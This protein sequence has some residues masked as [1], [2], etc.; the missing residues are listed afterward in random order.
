MFFNA[1]L[2]NF[3]IFLLFINW[4]IIMK[5]QNKKYK[6]VLYDY[7][8]E[9]VEIHNYDLFAKLKDKIKKS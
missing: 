8:V 1:Y 6:Q 5:N 3:E 9:S 2:V 7:D 4:W